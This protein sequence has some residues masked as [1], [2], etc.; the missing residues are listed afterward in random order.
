M[1]LR[2]T[3][4][5]L[6]L[7]DA[8]QE[9]VADELEGQD[10][11]FKEWIARS[12]RDARAQV[13]DMAVCMANGGGGTVVFGV[14]DKVRGRARA[15]VGVPGDIDVPALTSAIYNGTDPK[16]TAAFEELSVP[17]GTGRLLVMQ[18]FGGL[19]P[20]TDRKSVV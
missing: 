4:D 1:S 13:I 17:E 15:I 18:V 19:A 9:H 5:I 14:A 10:L 8:L 3:A 6:R 7:L 16:I 11:D 20:Y 2:S 12:V